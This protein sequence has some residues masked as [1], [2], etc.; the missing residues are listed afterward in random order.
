MK[1]IT[2]KLPE[3]EVEELNEFIKKEITPQNQNLLD[4]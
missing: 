2:I 1:T 3:E 4:I